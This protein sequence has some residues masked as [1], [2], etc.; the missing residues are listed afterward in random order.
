MK[1]P[2]LGDPEALVALTVAFCLLGTVVVIIAA[3]VFGCRMQ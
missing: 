2:S 1:L 3:N